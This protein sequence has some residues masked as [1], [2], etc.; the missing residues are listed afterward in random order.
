[1]SSKT[2]IARILGTHIPVS[3]LSAVCLLKAD[4]NSFFRRQSC[5]L[6]NQ[7][8]IF[9]PRWFLIFF[10]YGCAICKLHTVSFFDC[11][12][13]ASPW[14]KVTTEIWLIGLLYVSPIKHFYWFS[15]HACLTVGS[16]SHLLLW[17][18]VVALWFS[19][20]NF[21]PHMTATL[22]F[23][24]SIPSVSLFLFI[25]QPCLHLL[26]SLP[27]SLPHSLH[28]HLPDNKAVWL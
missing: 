12:S 9:W 1:M 8:N 6:H 14:G 23:I 25:H 22:T 19:L 13:A 21:S 17:A 10:F 2:N 11:L 27:L 18:S 24:L 28:Q 7:E 20:G 15:L 4:K 3:R 26:F 5:K 16:G